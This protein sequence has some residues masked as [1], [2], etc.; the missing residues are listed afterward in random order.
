MI[1]TT[2]FFTLSAF[3]DNNRHTKIR[4]NNINL[5]LGMDYG[6]VHNTKHHINQFDAV[7]DAKSVTLKL[8]I[9]SGSFSVYF[10]GAQ[11]L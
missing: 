7:T 9:I 10:K 3:F 6:K 8:L 11:F 1:S 4:E 2:L 5:S